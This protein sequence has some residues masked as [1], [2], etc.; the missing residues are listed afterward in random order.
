MDDNWFFG[1]RLT[2]DFFS[3]KSFGFN[4]KKMDG[5]KRLK[6]WGSV[7]ELNDILDSF[8]DGFLK[9]SRFSEEPDDFFS[10]ARRLRNRILK[11]RLDSD[12]DFEE[13]I[14]K[15]RVRKDSSRS[16][17]PESVN[18]YRITEVTNDL[19]RGRFD[20]RKSSVDDSSFSSRKSSTAN[21]NVTFPTSSDS[22]ISEASFDKSVSQNSDDSICTEKSANCVSEK[23]PDGTNKTQMENNECWITKS[24]SG[25]R[26]SEKKIND[27]LT[28][29]KT[30]SKISEKSTKR[31][32]FAEKSGSGSSLQEVTENTSFCERNGNKIEQKSSTETI[33]KKFK[34]FPAKGYYE[35]LEAKLFNRDEDEDEKTPV[36]RRKFKGKSVSEKIS[37]LIDEAVAQD[38]LFKISS[39]LQTDLDKI[40]DDLMD[41]K[42]DGLKRRR[43]NIFGVSA[44]KKN[45][46]NSRQNY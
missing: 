42:L 40:A 5:P 31:M 14:N 32:S 9:R 8:S 12:F 18:S 44:K 15:R 10:R 30:D 38:D 13:K 26:I 25:S 19:N 1:D 46:K 29:E 2:R 33:R 23:L 17:V 27:S 35:E 22:N 20:S 28:T 24:S 7:S 21:V 4:D 41:V 45:Y 37:K 11:E 3:R 43:R 6:S 39:T 16:S 36:F 34:P